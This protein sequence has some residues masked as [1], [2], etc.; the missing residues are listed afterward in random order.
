MSR[1]T[2][3]GQSP[4][5]DAEPSTAVGVGVDHQNLLR[6]RA[7]RR[8]NTPSSTSC[9]RTRT[10]QR[11]EADAGFGFRHSSDV[12]RRSSRVRLA[13]VPNI[14]PSISH[15]SSPPTGACRCHRRRNDYPWS[16]ATTGRLVLNNRA[17]SEGSR[18]SPFRGLRPCSLP[19]LT[20]GP[21]DPV[22]DDRRV[23]DLPRLPAIGRPHL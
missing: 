5:I 7:C 15:R 19:R 11:L 21:I 13:R 9:R 1:C 4:M 14:S 18:R 3:W 12:V 20:V 23:C 17:I 10:C 6:T 2:T 22:P 8:T 16:A